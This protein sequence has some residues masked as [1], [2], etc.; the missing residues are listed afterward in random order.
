MFEQ[1]AR[2]ACES[3]FDRPITHITDK[4]RTNTLFKV[5]FDGISPKKIK[6]HT[7][8]FHSLYK[9]LG[10]VYAKNYLSGATT[11][12]PTV[13]SFYQKDPLE[14]VHCAWYI[15]D[16]SEG[17]VLEVFHP[18]DYRK[19]TCLEIASA[20][21]Q[22]LA[23]MHNV[24]F[25]VDLE[26]IPIGEVLWSPDDEEFYL[27][28]KPTWIDNVSSIA[29]VRYKSHSDTTTISKDTVDRLYQ[30]TTD[31]IDQ[32]VTEDINPVLSNL[33]YRAGNLSFKN[34]HSRNKTAEITGVFDW[35]RALHG[36][37]QFGL[38]IGEFF[39]TNTCK[40]NKLRNEMQH[41]YRN[42][43]L[44]NLESEVTID[45]N[46]YKLYIGLQHLQQCRSFEYW[47]NTDDY[48]QSWRKSQE[49]LIL[50][51]I[52][53]LLNDSLLSFSPPQTH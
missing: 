23:R 8:E 16:Y 44:E 42:T 6:Y 43:Y 11:V 17:D 10:G 51:D 21:G 4:S 29:T 48:T 36:D 27:N 12:V 41:A 35:D 31:M 30:Y 25:N 45:P 49:Q 47:Y 40:Q 39:L 19:D 13:Y 22:T 1:H 28:D 15:S 34:L 24:T 20:M 50:N 33:D 18:E 2:R 53:Q 52:E 5:E 7:F 38:A 32:H 26:H 3:H 14:Q 9:F 46:L 37:W